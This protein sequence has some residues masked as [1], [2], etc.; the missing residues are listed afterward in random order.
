MVLV[1][2]LLT[3][4]LLLALTFAVTSSAAVSNGAAPVASAAAEIRTADSKV[5]VTGAD[6]LVK[7]PDDDKPYS[8]ACDPC[9][10]IATLSGK[11]STLDTKV[12][13]QCDAC[14]LQ[15]RVTAAEK[16]IEDLKRSNTAQVDDL[17]R[18]LSDL[19]KGLGTVR[20][21]AGK[22]LPGSSPEAPGG[23]SCQDMLIKARTD[24]CMADLLPLKSGN[25]WLRFS[26]ATFE[27][28]CDMETDG[29]GWTLF[30]GIST[31]MGAGSW[32]RYDVKANGLAL[33]A[34]GKIPTGFAKKPA[35][36][37]E[38]IR[39]DGTGWHVDMKTSAPTQAWWLNPCVE[40]SQQASII[41]ST[42]A[43]DPPP[44]NIRVHNNKGPG[45]HGIGHVYMA[46]KDGH[47]TKIKGVL[48]RNSQGVSAGFYYL[49]TYGSYANWLAPPT[50]PLGGWATQ[51]STRSNDIHFRCSG[52]IT[53]VNWK[54]V[55]M[56]YR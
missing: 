33:T 32:A 52:F 8:I 47:K 54:S 14:S 1:Y 22:A 27:A 17:K 6:I 41:I 21:C 51:C 19:R 45:C 10:S 44:K 46:P 13:A 39:V 36:T 48:P 38:R 55:R 49:L 40:G 12:N 35:G 34:G 50:S 42:L 5:I 4:H 16:E 25:Y 24:P 30:T 7:T 23:S 28:Y 20:M 9:S 2:I 26:G 15:A 31:L 53:Q 18:E 29:G 3:T 56:F 43:V 11:L 37:T